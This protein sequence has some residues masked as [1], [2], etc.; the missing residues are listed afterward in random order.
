MESSISDNQPAPVQIVETSKSYVYTIRD[1]KEYLGE[2]LLI[3]F[4]VLLALILTEYI[5]NLHEKENTRSIMKSIV[6]EL[7][8]NKTSL[9]EMN[10][11]NL[12]VLNNIDSVIVNKKLQQQLVSNDAFHLK[13][14]APQGALYR[15]LDNEAWTIAKNNNIMSKLDVE[16][17]SVLTKVYDDQNRVMKVEDE[18]AKIILGRESRDPVKIH[19]TLVIIKDIYHA[20]AVDRNEGLLHRIDEAIKKVE[21]Y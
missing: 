10:L 9:Q 18:V 14:I 16:T 5:N 19:L 6:A 4:S 13:V 12:Q 20:W 1:W 17:L 7:K 8:Q 15:Y 11:Y 3:I 2:S 21:A